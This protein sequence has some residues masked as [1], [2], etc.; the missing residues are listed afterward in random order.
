MYFQL[1]EETRFRYFSLRQ[2]LLLFLLFFPFIGQSADPHILNNLRTIL[3]IW[4]WSKVGREAKC[5]FNVRMGSDENYK[6]L[7]WTGGED[8]GGRGGVVRHLLGSNSR[9]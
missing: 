6:K 9:G 5:Y 8:V 7:Y 1:S 3:E 2:F 4:R